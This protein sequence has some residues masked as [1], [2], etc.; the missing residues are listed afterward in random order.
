M[1]ELGLC[2]KKLFVGGGG[3]IDKVVLHDVCCH[4]AKYK[5][6]DI[7]VKVLDII[8]LFSKIANESCQMFIH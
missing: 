1:I 8:I 3:Y 7:L 2:E 6:L 4:I 5:T